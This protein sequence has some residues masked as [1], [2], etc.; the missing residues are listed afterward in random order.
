MN[1]ERPYVIARVD[2]SGKWDVIHIGPY[3]V[4]KDLREN[5]AEALAKALNE[6]HKRT[7]N[8]V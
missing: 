5:E 2:A 7:I 4:A 1:H 6:Q 8:A 3:V